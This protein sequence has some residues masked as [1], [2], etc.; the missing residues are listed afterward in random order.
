MSGRCAEPEETCHSLFVN[1]YAKGNRR[2]RCWGCT[3]GA[4]IR[5][6]LRDCSPTR[7]A[8]RDL[9]ETLDVH[10]CHNKAAHKRGGKKRKC[11]TT[12]KN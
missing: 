10:E 2:S 7:A 3:R 12:G 11:R 5:L 1:A 8:V 6:A 4:E 9:L